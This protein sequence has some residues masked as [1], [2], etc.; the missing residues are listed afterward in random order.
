NEEGCA[1]PV[2]SSCSLV[3]VGVRRRPEASSSR[4]S[5]ALTADTHGR[6]RAIVVGEALSSLPAE[7]ADAQPSRRAIAVDLAA[8]ERAAGALLAVL[9]R[10]AVAVEVAVHRRRHDAEAGAADFV[11]RAVAVDH[12]A[13]GIFADVRD[14]FR[15]RRA[16]V[17]ALAEAR[18]LAN[19]ADAGEAG[20]A[21]GVGA[22]G[23]RLA[24]AGVAALS[25]RAIAVGGAVRLRRAD[26]RA[27]RAELSRRARIAGAA[28]DHRLALVV[29]ARGV[30]P[31]VGVA[32][33]RHIGHAL[34]GEEIAQRAG[35]AV[36]G[37][38]A[39]VWLHDALA[40]DADLAGGARDAGAGIVHRDALAHLA[41]EA[42][43]AVAVR[44]AAG[45]L[46][47]A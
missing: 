27:R 46:R 16:L 13:A 40:A 12:A 47:H 42:R 28:A 18:R 21:V 2:V 11:R 17:V 25:R 33:A 22:A 14:A 37:L 10:R 20:G 24:E 41:D 29:D 36:G 6:W 4:R 44:H 26:A 30:R 9:V 31:A 8:I 7:S 23:E 3:A 38:R 35:R 43:R 19:R 32:R 45:L 34:A 5:D 15:R 39:T 1:S